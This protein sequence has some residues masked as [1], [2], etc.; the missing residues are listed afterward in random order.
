MKD[1][2]QTAFYGRNGEDPLSIALRE[3][4]A[5]KVPSNEWTTMDATGKLV[6]TTEGRPYAIYSLPLR[7]RCDHPIASG[8][9][10]FRLGPD[11][12]GALG[13][14]IPSPR[15]MA[16]GN[17]KASVSE[18]LQVLGNPVQLG[19]PSTVNAD[20]ALAIASMRTNLREFCSMLLGRATMC[21]CDWKACAVKAVTTN[22]MF[23][24]K[25]K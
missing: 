23:V 7:E 22:T 12:S 18:V 15:K 13:R 3:S 17:R 25:Q 2:P 1:D 4:K 11:A 5:Q 8:P 21:W 10:A 19:Y 24:K 16:P 9:W 14:Y 6:P 20:A